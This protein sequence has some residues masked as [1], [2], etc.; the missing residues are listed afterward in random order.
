MLQAIENGEEATLATA[1]AG[2]PGF[3]EET[4]R[5]G[6]TVN[7]NQAS[8]R[9]AIT[10]FNTWYVAGLAHVLSAEGETLCDVYRA[11]QPT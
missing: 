7:V 3:W 10:E 1:L 5:E 2:Q 8:T 6:K 4:D 9:L 11:S